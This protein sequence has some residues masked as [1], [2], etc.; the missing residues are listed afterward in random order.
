MPGRC[1]ALLL[2]LLPVLTPASASA[3]T[4]A[5]GRIVGRVLDSATGRPLTGARVA[6][7]GTPLS[8]ISGVDGRYTVQ[9]VPG[10]IRSLAVSYLGFADKT[11][12]GV[13]VAAG[14]STKLDVTLEP[15]ALAL[16]AITVT[17]ATERGSVNRALDEQ[18]TSTGVVN[19]VTAEQIARSPDGDAAAAVQRVS[20]VTVQ[21]G[22][23]IFVRG[24]GERY[25]TTSLN[26]ARIPS[27]EPER[28]V[29]PLDLFP[30]GLIQS[31]TTSK[32]FTPDQPGDF[33]GAQ[34]NIQTREFPARRQTVFSFSSGYNTAA[35]GRSIVSAPTEGGEWFGFGGSARALPQPADEAGNFQQRRLTQEEINGIAGS[36]R[37]RWTAEEQTAT[38]NFSLGASTGGTGPLL[39]REVGFLLSGTYSNSVEARLNEVRTRAI[40]DASGSA[41]QAARF[42]G[43]TGRTSVLWGGLF[44]LS[45]LVGS[46]SRIALNNT[47]NRT[48]DNEARS[49]RGFD[50]NFGSL[51][52]FIDR[53]RFI[54]RSVRSNQLVGEHQL[55]DRHRF[56]WQI[57]SSGVSRGEPDRSEILY[58]AETDFSTGQVLEPAW[59]G[60]SN[61]AAVRTFGDLREDTWEAG[62]NYGIGFGGTTAPHRFKIGAL[63]RYTSRDADNR[64]YSIFT[65]SPL[66][67]EVRQQSP[68][69]ILDGRYAVPGSSTL[70]VAPLGAGGSYAARDGLVAGYGM[71][72]YALRPNV[73]LVGGARV[74]YSNVEVNAQPT[75]GRPTSTHP[76]YTD[77]LP[78]LAVN[79]GLTDRQNLRFS[80]SRTLS[81]PEYRELSPILYREVIGAENVFGDPNLRR[82]LIQNYD[83]R[84]EWYP[85]TGEVLSFGVFAKRFR[86]PIERV[87]V[88][89]SGTALVTFV[90]ARSAENY[91]V[92][93]EAR[94]GLGTLAES[95]EP[96]SVFANATLMHSDIEI[97]GGVASRTNHQ[98]AM[99]GQAPYVVNTGL[100]YASLGGGFSS[101]LLYNVVGRRIV[102]AAEAPLED[103]YEQPR[104]VLDFSLRSALRRG[105][106]LRFDA[107]NLL[108]EPYEV[109]Q[110]AL[111]REYYRSGRTF[112]LGFTWQPTAM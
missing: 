32:T 67:V 63:G 54:E 78:S 96:L 89:A 13:Q 93:L 74:E 53:L 35:T 51:P 71:V 1:A 43:E 98:R 61:E 25:T 101:T 45:T 41:S 10:G 48:S 28:K 16:E 8:A 18:R 11:V 86:D 95:L 36:F 94:K 31:I 59:Y 103:L 60:S 88:A 109:T 19:A 77:V 37:N 55:S 14:G 47:Y 91:G 83:V 65:I 22:R 102:A 80:A 85:N 112:S 99:V 92:E 12:T 20:G 106:A 69:Q 6:V 73:Q 44:N 84:Y 81:R 24:L 46:S 50:E 4:S 87:Y 62:A 40:P 100:T 90:N 72:E 7:Q 23:F 38:P 57:T 66:S 26:G 33:S 17:A 58:A 9:G 108:D 34:V 52:L 97:G 49:E 75:T 64:A 110:G 68:E 82:T 79:I 2:L 3:Q 107:R 104:H 29:V 76:T 42:E 39:G 27:P 30:T 111:L 70:S 56:D 5:G 21:D 15:Q 105:L